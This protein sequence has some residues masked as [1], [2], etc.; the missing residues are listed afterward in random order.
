MGSIDDRTSTESRG[1]DTGGRSH[2]WAKEIL[3]QAVDRGL[4]IEYWGEEENRD[5]SVV[6]RL[7]ATD[8]V[9]MRLDRL[10]VADELCP[11]VK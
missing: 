11:L 7:I 4:M 10:K 8:M 9:C 1:D 2:C 3:K 6:V 5:G